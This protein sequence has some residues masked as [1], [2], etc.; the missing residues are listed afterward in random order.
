MVKNTKFLQ[1]SIFFTIL[2]TYIEIFAHT[3]LSWNLPDTNFFP[4]YYSLPPTVFYYF[5]IILQQ[6]DAEW[7]YSYTDLPLD[8]SCRNIQTQQH[9]YDDGEHQS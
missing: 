4:T 8:R 5:K 3:S 6:E 1:L 7:Q 9:R 2:S